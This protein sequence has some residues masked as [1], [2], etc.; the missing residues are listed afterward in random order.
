MSASLPLGVVA[1]IRDA[2]GRFLV[3]KRSEQV[4]APGQWCFPGG[5]VHPGESP[6][7]A[8][9]REVREELGA[10]VHSGRLLWQST[11]PWKVKLWWYEAHLDLSAPIKPD[12]REVS[13]WGW[14][15]LEQLEAEPE[16]LESNRAFVQAVR[17]GQVEL[18]SEEAP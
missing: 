8:L 17:K 14:R 2:Q 9:V 12:P 3:V 1:V 10:E 6:Q 13:A 16:L 4:V 7:Q 15:T 5:M 11:A 18:S